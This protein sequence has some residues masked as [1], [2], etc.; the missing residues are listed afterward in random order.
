MR[1]T[2]KAV[3]GPLSPLRL[4]VPLSAMHVDG[5]KTLALAAQ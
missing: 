4:W 1:A 5:V 2:T 3:K